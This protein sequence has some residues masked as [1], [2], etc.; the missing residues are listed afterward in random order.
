MN[1]TTIL[2]MT[3]LYGITTYF[4]GH[5]GSHLFNIK[6]G[7]ATLNPLFL[8]ILWAYNVTFLP[9]AVLI[10]IGYKTFWYYPVIILVLSQIVRFSLVSL[11]TTLKIHKNAWMISLIGIVAIPISLLFLIYLSKYL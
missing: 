10:F 7:R 2:L 9:W 5:Q 6:N 1:Y 8:I 3:L 4:H 11:E